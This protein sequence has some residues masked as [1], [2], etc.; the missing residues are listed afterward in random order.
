MDGCC[1][2][3]LKLI[4]GGADSFGGKPKVTGELEGNGDCADAVGSLVGSGVADLGGNGVA[5][6]LGNC[7]GGGILFSPL[8]FEVFST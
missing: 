1:C 2:D 8:V 3:K 6:G 7:T 5:S 4:G